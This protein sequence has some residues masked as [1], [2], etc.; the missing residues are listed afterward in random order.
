MNL[1]TIFAFVIVL[2]YL[3]VLLFF[4]VALVAKIKERAIE[5]KKDRYKDIER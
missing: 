2:I 3:S 5:K 4:I 1:F